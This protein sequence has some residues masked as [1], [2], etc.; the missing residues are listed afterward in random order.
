[1]EVTSPREGVYTVK[2][3]H[4]YPVFLDNTSLIEVELIGN[5]KIIPTL[6]FGGC[7][8]LEKVTL[9]NTITKISDGSFNGCS[10]LN[11]IIIPELVTYI[12]IMAFSGCKLT[13]IEIPENVETVNNYAFY[14]CTDLTRVNL[15][16]NTEYFGDNAFERCENLIYINIP[17][18]VVYIGESCFRDCISLP[19]IP[20]IGIIETILEYTFSGCQSFK[21][22]IIPK[23]VK[24][25]QKSAFEG[26]GFKS[27]EFQE[28]LEYI[29]EQAFGYCSNLTTVSFPN[30]IK[31]IAKDS[32]L[33][34]NNRVSIKTLNTK[35]IFSGLYNCM[36]NLKKIQ[37]GRIELSTDT[38]EI[39]EISISTKYEIVQ[40][41][42]FSDCPNLEY[43]EFP[44]TVEYVG[45]EIFGSGFIDINFPIKFRSIPNVY[46]YSGKLNFIEFPESTPPNV[47]RPFQY[48]DLSVSEFTLPNEVTRLSGCSFAHSKVSKV[49]LSSNIIEIPN[50]CFC[51]SEIISIIAKSATKL[52][53]YAFYGCRKLESTAFSSNLKSIGESCFEATNITSIDLPFYITEIGKK[54]FAYSQLNEF[55]IPGSI[56]KINSSLFES[57][58]NLNNVII[59]DGVTEIGEDVFWDSALVTFHAPEVMKISTRAL[60]QT[61]IVHFICPKKITLIPEYLFLSSNYL[62]RVTLHDGVT[63]IDKSAFGNCLKLRIVEFMHSV[64]YIGELAFSMTNITEFI[65]PKGCSL[66][67]S[68]ISFCDRLQFIAFDDN[69]TLKQYYTWSPIWNGRIPI[70]Y[71]GRNLDDKSCDSG[72]GAFIFLTGSIVNV[73]DKYNMNTFYEIP[74]NKSLKYKGEY[75][76]IFN[77]YDIIRIISQFVQSFAYNLG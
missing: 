72:L 69:V 74:V 73:H 76:T 11:N 32:F 20:S 29:E 42:A 5:F 45:F 6:C 55:T 49:I 30:S 52:N 40:S 54:A 38:D 7:R 16:G 46:E 67:S 70:I 12:G 35:I 39:R 33:R 36:D 62:E 22:L 28:G 23:T 24:R 27:I 58:K 71:S 1:M 64:K 66:Y 21:S 37:I 43:V 77:E 53:S 3:S 19:G 8:N 31:R 44:E 63:R 60:A 13:N 18:T 65:I 17:Q 75:H 10:K 4:L 61:K 50:S 47:I 48:S 57:C 2:G 56:T 15:H 51:Y 34:C 9:C 26:C 68:T 41:E 59:H 14:G 25:I